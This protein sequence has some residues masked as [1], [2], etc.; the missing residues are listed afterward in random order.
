MENNIHFV[1][2]REISNSIIVQYGHNIK[3]QPKC[4]IRE[5]SFRTY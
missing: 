4:E 3:K 1:C 2:L 5:E